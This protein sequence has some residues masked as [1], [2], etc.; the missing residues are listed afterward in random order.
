MPRS[1][2]DLL[3]EGYSHNELARSARRGELVRL[4]RG[5][6]LQPDEVAADATP[7]HRQLI[8]ATIPYGTDGVVSHL[9]AAVLHDLPV[10]GDP[11]D[12]VHLTRSHGD[13]TPGL[14]TCTCTSPR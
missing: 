5:S 2:A 13:R 1:T 10:W 3:A 9:S 14:G 4:R 12:R 8:T 11:L 7:R 6:Y